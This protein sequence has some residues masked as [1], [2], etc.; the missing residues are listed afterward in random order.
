MPPRDDSPDTNDSPDAPASP[1]GLRGLWGE[2]SEFCSLI[3]PIPRGLLVGGVALF[4]LAWWL[5]LSVP[6]VPDPPNEH[7][8]VI[9][10]DRWFDAHRPAWGPASVG[11]FES[12]PVVQCF[13]P[14]AGAVV[15]IGW[16][17]AGEGVVRCRAARADE[18]RHGVPVICEPVARG[19]QRARP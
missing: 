9:A 11:P 8:A 7:D 2:W 17:P 12:T 16:D 18:Q 15:C 4:A 6:A 1:G 19:S 3:A 5:L 14:D 13:A 10:A